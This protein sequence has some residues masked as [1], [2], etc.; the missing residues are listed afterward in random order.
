MKQDKRRGS[1]VYFLR[2]RA[3]LE[4]F[5]EAQVS[6]DI[7]IRAAE[8]EQ[9]RAMRI[10]SVLD[11]IGG[12]RGSGVSDKVGT[13]VVNYDALL[14]YLRDRIRIYATQIAERMQVLDAIA[15]PEARDVLWKQYIE[16]EG[17]QDIAAEMGVTRKTIHAWG[18]KG[19]A[20][21]HEQLESKKPGA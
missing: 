11:G 4:G 9:D 19:L 7:A 12:G 5:R 1:A 3:W 15:T 18:L 8:R 14:P 17:V 13:G 20:E 16:G 21:V 10:T 2:E 6:L